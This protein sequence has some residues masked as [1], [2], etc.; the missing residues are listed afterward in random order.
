MHAPPE[1]IAAAAWQCPQGGWTRAATDS[2]VG[3]RPPRP[4]SAAPQA[5]SA[6]RGLRLP[7]PVGPPAAQGAVAAEPP[8]AQA[9]PRHQ[10][11]GALSR[12]R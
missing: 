7:T 11:P 3:G 2:R 9:R 6:Q 8:P 4:P 10:Q 5:A 1:Q 12:G